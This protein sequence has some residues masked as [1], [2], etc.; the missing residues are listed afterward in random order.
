MSASSAFVR[1]APSSPWSSLVPGLVLGLLAF[2]T[3]IV[4]LGQPA[5]PPSGA[6][7]YR[8]ELPGGGFTPP[9]NLDEFFSTAAEPTDIANGI[10]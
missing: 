7:T 8:V 10:Y 4:T 6:P 3:P 1:T 9:A 5:L 2:G